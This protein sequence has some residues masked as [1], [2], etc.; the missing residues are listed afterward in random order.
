MGTP[1]KVMGLEEAAR[2][3]FNPFDVTKVWPHA[4]YP[5]R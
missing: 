5:L 4:D 1:A 3:S 2:A